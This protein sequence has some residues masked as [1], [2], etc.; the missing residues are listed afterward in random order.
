MKQTIVMLSVRWLTELKGTSEAGFVGW[1]KTTRLTPRSPP[2]SP[3]AVGEGGTMEP[4]IDCSQVGQRIGPMSH[5]A[6][7]KRSHFG[8]ATRQCRVDRSIYG[9]RLCGVRR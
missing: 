9:V 8:I 4:I 2:A 5:Q 1:L 3:M 6:W 7:T